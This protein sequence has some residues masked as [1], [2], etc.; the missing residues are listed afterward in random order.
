MDY[1]LF[2][3]QDCNFQSRSLLVPSKEF[4]SIEKRQAQLNALK[5]CAKT[6]IITNKENNTIVLVD[7]VLFNNYTT[8]SIKI[9]DARI[10]KSGQMDYNPQYS[11]LYFDLRYYA[12]WSKNITPYEYQPIDE[13]DSAWIPHMYKDF[14]GGFNHILNFET[15]KNM[16]F[17][18]NKPI[19]IVASFLF[20]ESNDGIYTPPVFDT[21]NEMM[22]VC[23]GF[24]PK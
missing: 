15:C 13:A 8:R 4:T 21:V 10:L 14:C 19:N 9:Q 5:N 23:Y 3:M 2:I 17:I 1:I 6:V 24:S 20:L 22:R 18:D 16:T 7:N 11:E 12:D